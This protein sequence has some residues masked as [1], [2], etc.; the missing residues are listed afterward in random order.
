MIPQDSEIKEDA[1]W[2]GLSWLSGAHSALFSKVVQ[3]LKEKGAADIE[4]LGG[5]VIPAEDIPGLKE[6]GVLEVFPPGTS[7]QTVVDFIN[8]H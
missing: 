4:V 1:K 7:S 6:A 2:V 5:G 8:S 3:L